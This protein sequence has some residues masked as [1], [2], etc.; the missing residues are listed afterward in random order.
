V[1]ISSAC[2]QSR[3]HFAPAEYAALQALPPSDRTD[4]FYRCWTRKEAY[5]KALGTGLSTDLASFEVTLGDCARLVR[6][7]NGATGRWTL[8]DLPVADGAAAAL[9]AQTDGAPLRVAFAG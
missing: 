3:A 4:V 1:S 9:A 8:R 2:V 7:S 5:L 6:C